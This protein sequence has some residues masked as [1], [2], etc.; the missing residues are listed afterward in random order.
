[1]LWA[2][3]CS[4]K[5][6]TAPLRDQH[7]RSHLD[8]LDQRKPILV[9]A[10]ATLKDDELQERLVAC[11]SSTRR[12]VRRLK[13]SRLATLSRKP[14]YLSGSPS[15]ACANRNGIRK[16]QITH[17]AKADVYR[18][19]KGDISAVLTYVCF[20]P[21]SGQAAS[22]MLQLKLGSAQRRAPQAARPTVRSTAAENR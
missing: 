3:Y 8:Y 6:A 20:S 13:L 22:A 7:M 16:R 18:G 15:R 4:D 19:S 21:E 17:R 10:G 5:A 11:S 1:M 12:R 14:A 2:I 9:L